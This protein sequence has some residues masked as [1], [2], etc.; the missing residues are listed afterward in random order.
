MRIRGKRIIAV[1]VALAMVAQPVMVMAE[2]T[3]ES[4]AVQVEESLET[5][6]TV[7]QPDEVLNDEQLETE[8]AASHSE[9]I[10]LNAANFPDESFL[11]KL[12]ELDTDGKGYLVCNEIEYLDLDDADIESLKGIENFHKLSDLDCSNNNLS[13]IDLS[14]NTSLE[15]LSFDS[16]QLINIDL[17]KN[18]SLTYLSCEN[19]YLTFLDFSQNKLLETLNCSCNNMASLDLSGLEKLNDVK[20]EWN[21]LIELNI[22]GCK[23]LDFLNCEYN[24]LGDDGIIKDD[25]NPTYL[26]C[27]Y[28]LVKGYSMSDEVAEMATE[29]LDGENS[30]DLVSS[31]VISEPVREFRPY[32]SVVYDVYN[33]VKG[34]LYKFTVPAYTSFTL[35]FEDMN[36]DAYFFDK[37]DEGEYE[38]WYEIEHDTDENLD[39]DAKGNFISECNS[40]SYANMTNQDETYYLLVEDSEDGKATRFTTEFEDSIV[41]KDEVGVFGYVNGYITNYLD[42]KYPD[43]AG[44]I[45]WYSTDALDDEELVEVAE[46]CEGTC[47]FV[48]SDEDLFEKLNSNGMLADMA[49]IIDVERYTDNAFAYTVEEGTYDG[50]LKA[51]TGEAIPGSFEYNTRIAEEVLGTSEPDE[52]Q[53]MLSTPEKFLKVAQKMKDAGYYM[54]S[55]ADILALSDSIYDNQKEAKNLAAALE[56]GGYDKAEANGYWIWS[57][58]WYNDL[59]ADDVFGIFAVPWMSRLIAES[60]ETPDA[61]K[62]IKNA[63]EGPVAY[64]YRSVFYAVQMGTTDD[65]AKEI[66]ETICCNE[67]DM[68]ALSMYIPEDE[69]YNYDYDSTYFPNN[70][71]AAQKKYDDGVTYS[72]KWLFDTD[73]YPVWISVAENLGS[74]RKT[75]SIVAGDTNGDNNV[76]ISD[77]MQVLN[78]VSGK[79][80]LIGNAFTAGDVTGDGKVDLQD[81]MK[82]L[83][84]VSGKSKEL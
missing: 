19:N 12:K 5:E 8:Y 65:M 48:S 38:H 15:Y 33:S 22:S 57:E 69:D 52:V 60:N 56:E 64:Y 42:E 31:I 51:V 53:A 84:F 21:Y 27:N 34:K 50:T 30:T 82:I 18:T 74:D 29:I 71:Y 11:A 6:V 9:K 67:D 4:T 75:E 77:L 44:K 66:L 36:A 14:K 16:N 72:D 73:P 2:E 43:Y 47:I 76:N 78:H 45:K 40:H 68:Y 80:T 37:N 79:S 17:S 1:A 20:C 32:N 59:N 70:K 3:A 24:R 28:N 7:V 83:N 63:C 58:E 61:D 35:T 39:F 25:I 41:E 81:L 49:D 13:S 10:E 26:Y 55:G 54:T 23:A 46:K 62:D